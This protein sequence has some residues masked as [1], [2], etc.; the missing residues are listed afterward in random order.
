M[1]RHGGG[2]DVM[3][4]DGTTVQARLNRNLISY[5]ALT[6]A[7]TLT[8]ILDPAQGPRLKA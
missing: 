2:L 4:Y 8:L 6:S 7:M 5:L 1:Q 3:V